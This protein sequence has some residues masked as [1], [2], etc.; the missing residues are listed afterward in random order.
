MCNR[1]RISAKQA[2]V[3]R[4][5]GFE[6]PYAPDEV[7]PPAREIFPTGKKTARH[8]PIV[9]RSTAGNRPL[10]MAL[11]EW[12]FPTKVPSKRNPEIK[13]DKY[14]TNA[15]TLKSSPRWKPSLATAERRCIVP[16]TWFA[17]PHPE[18]GVGDDNKPR[19]MWF[20]L[21]D[22]P[23]G[24]FAGLWRP[25]ERGEAYA[26]AT[27][28]PNEFVKPWHPKAMPVILRPCDLLQWLD[29]SA[30]EALELVRP[31]GGAMIRQV[32]TPSDD[33]IEIDA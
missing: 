16:F 27:T 13:L 33:L 28:N 30:A 22:Q 25:T 21:P 3:M 29:G 24:F 14:V 6:P 20:A 18:G 5:C 11:L 23:I 1:Y 12:G 15:R 2:A 7:F 9:R 4:A 8:G 19:Q 31:Y 10:E 17:E 26:F 32:E